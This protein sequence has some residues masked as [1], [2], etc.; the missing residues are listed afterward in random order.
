MRIPVARPRRALVAVLTAL[1]SPLLIL[2]APRE[3]ASQAV[4]KESV[5][6][7]VMTISA[8]NTFPLTKK[9]AMGLGK[10]LFLQ[11]PFDLRDVIV[12]DPDRVD[13]VVQSVDR[14][15]LVAKKAGNTNVIFFDAQGQQIMTLDVSIG[16]DL[17]ELDNLLKRLLPGSNIRTELAGATIVL[18]GTVRTPLDSSRAVDLATQFAASNKN[19]TAGISA[20]STSQGGVTTTSI[21]GSGFGQSAPSNPKPVINLLAVDGEDQVMLK[22]TVAEVQRS[23]LK[24]MG[25]NL[26]SSFSIDNFGLALGTANSFNVTGAALGALGKAG[27]STA[28]PPGQGCGVVLDAISTI[29]PLVGNSGLSSVWGDGKHCLSQTLKALEREG[30]VRTL[31]EP[32]LTAVSGESAKFLAG[33]EYPIPVSASL[34]VFAISFKEFGVGLG[35]TPVVL[36]EGRISLKIDIDVSELSTEGAIVMGGTQIPALKKR[37]ARSTVELASGASIALAGLISETT[38]SSVEGFPG[39]KDLPVLG[40]LFRSKDFTRNETELVVI[41]TPYIVRSTAARK[42][43]RPDENLAPASDLKGNFLGHL[44]RVYGRGREMPSGGLKGDYGFI[45]E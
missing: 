32:N 14:V 27:L 41:V 26:A 38:R 22:V 21:T 15:F 3:A 17:T 8:R 25:I 24:Q 4:E 9:V 10:T 12:S 28:T 23:I 13:A 42:L 1:L 18:Q 45:V 16:S 7:S 44:N 34:G 5:Q 20:V 29:P 6:N 31:A 30:L 2:A 43:A 19:L 37:Q 36:S 35:F 33:G 39:L 40:T 11:F